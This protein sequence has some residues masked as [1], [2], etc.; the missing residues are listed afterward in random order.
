VAFDLQKS[1]TIGFCRRE[2]LKVKRLRL[3]KAKTRNG[4]QAP[5]AHSARE[6]LVCATSTLVARRVH[7]KKKREER[8]K[9]KLKR[10]EHSI[11]KLK[12][13]NT[14]REPKAFFLRFFLNATQE[15]YRGHV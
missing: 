2:A 8:R 7:K 10:N 1:C 11:N 14:K 4:M 9:V 6:H 12:L 3:S 13:N 15:K 5:K